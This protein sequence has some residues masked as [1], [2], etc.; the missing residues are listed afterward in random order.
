[1]GFSS[2]DVFHI[3]DYVHIWLS[4]SLQYLDPSSSL[5]NLSTMHWNQTSPFSLFPII[6]SITS[7]PKDGSPLIENGRV[8]IFS[9]RHT[10]NNYE[11]SIIQP[12]L[13]HMNTSSLGLT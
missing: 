7:L 6:P 5:E 2:V 1:L 4:K 11:C 13:L 8:D 3:V 12:T 10:K 9:I